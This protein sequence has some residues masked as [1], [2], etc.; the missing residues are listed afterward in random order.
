MDQQLRVETS[1]WGTRVLTSA[2]A[3]LSDLVV[4][5]HLQNQ[6]IV[7]QAKKSFKSTPHEVKKFPLPLGTLLPIPVGLD[8]GFG[9]CTMVA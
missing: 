3:A 5:C 6:V 7:D 2:P 1:A 8:I 4:G 9:F